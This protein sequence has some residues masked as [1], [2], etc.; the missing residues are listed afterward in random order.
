MGVR[1]LAAV[2]RSVHSIAPVSATST[3]TG[4]VVDVRNAEAVL[5]EVAVGAITTLDAS[6]NLFTFKVQGGNKSDGSDM[7]DL[8]AGDYYA[9]T[10]ELYTTEVNAS[11]ADPQVPTTWNL[12]LDDKTVASTNYQA[13][14]MN[15]EN[16]SYM[17]VVATATG[18]PSV[19][20]GANLVKGKMS[21]SPA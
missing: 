6:S 14:I 12:K 16:Y 17:R 9:Q 5:L 2:V 18:S 8:A 11:T 19:L 3:K 4:D 20:M 10:D 7:A 13:G 21:Q 15:T 1:D